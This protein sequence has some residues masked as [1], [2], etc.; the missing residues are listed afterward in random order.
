MGDR[1]PW[2]SPSTNSDGEASFLLK[3]TFLS[4]ETVDNTGG[5]LQAKGC[6]FVAFTFSQKPAVGRT[7]ALSLI[8]APLDS[9]LA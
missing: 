4:L 9:R 2:P 3:K 8:V 1:W 6:L 7:E 5:E